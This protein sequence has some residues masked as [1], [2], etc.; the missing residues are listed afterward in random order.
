[1]NNIVGYID[2]NNSVKN[3]N[4]MFKRI[5]CR[6][7]FKE[8]EYD[9]LKILV[10]TQSLNEKR[11]KRIA[12]KIKE[13]GINKIVLAENCANKRGLFIKYGIDILDGKF[14]MKNMLKEILVYMYKIRGTEIFNESLYITTDNDT[15]FDIIIDTANLF[16][17]LNIVT[18]KIKKLKRMDK[19][20]ESN[21]D[22]VCSITNNITK[23]LR[24]AKIIVNFNYDEKFFSEAKLNRNAIIINLSK[25]KLNLKSSFNGTIIENINIEYKQNLMEENEFKNF[26]KSLLLESKI[27]GKSYSEIKK[28][29]N[30]ADS[31]IIDLYGKNGKIFGEEIKN[32]LS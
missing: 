18:R 2:V 14:I 3:F 28:I 30:E 25:E 1:M 19:K 27:L 4:L 5:F 10:D 16:K 6:V 13:I 22:I 8:L 20:I 26:N 24:R 31:K 15:D 21:T 29:L 11:I 12:N 17:S 32:N 7:K 9:K 23:G